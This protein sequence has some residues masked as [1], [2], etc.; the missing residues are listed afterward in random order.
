MMTSEM[1]KLETSVIGWDDFLFFFAG[2]DTPSL[3]GP[4]ES[5]LVEEPDAA[6][7]YRFLESYGMVSLSKA[8]PW[9]HVRHNLENEQ[10]QCLISADWVH[11]GH[12]SMQRTWHLKFPKMIHGE[13]NVYVG[14][15]QAH[16]YM[17]PGA[18]VGFDYEGNWRIGRNTDASLSMGEGDGS[19]RAPQDCLA[20]VT[21]DL[22]IQKFYISF[23]D[24]NDEDCGLIVHKLG[25]NWTHAR[26]GFLD[27]E[28]R[29]QSLRFQVVMSSPTWTQLTERT[30]GL[31]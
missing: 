6:S 31:W 26:C 14:V 29:R 24:D 15:T 2:G 8:S 12:S 10:R 30:A 13:G 23:L 16:S 4:P 20:M 9:T 11:K 19:V 1:N 28:A 18:T 3:K 5:D 21:V 7:T 17:L 25:G 27:H 22:Q